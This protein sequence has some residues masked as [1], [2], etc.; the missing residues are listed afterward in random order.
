MSFNINEQNW[1]NH[2]P[3][4]E[5]TIGER[6]GIEANDG[7][8]MSLRDNMFAVA[9]GTARG[10]IILASIEE[11]KGK[12]HS[13]LK[14]RELR[15]VQGLAFLDSSC[16]VSFHVR[17]V[18]LWQMEFDASPTPSEVHPTHV[19]E[20]ETKG[21]PQCCAYDRENQ[22]IIVG[23][24]RGNLSYFLIINQ[25]D[26][27]ADGEN[28]IKS[29]CALTRVHQKQ[30]VTSIKWLNEN[31]IL[32]A[33]N[34]GCLHVSY[35]HGNLLQRGWSFSASCLTGI[36]SIITTNSS[37][38]AESYS[39]P[40][41][42]TGYHGNT[43]RV[44]DVESGYEYIRCDTGGRQRILDCRFN[45]N[46][47][48]VVAT[49]L[50][51]QLV[52]CQAKKDGSNRIFIQHLSM[53]NVPKTIRGH[54]HVARGVKLHGETIFDSSFFTL[55]NQELVFLVTASEDCTTRISAWKDGRIIDSVQ[56]TP[57][58]S[59]CRCI[60]VSKID[61]RSVLLVVGGGKLVLQFF[62]IKAGTNGSSTN[63]ARNLEIAFL[64]NGLTSKRGATIDH[65]IN[66][67]SALPL[68]DG[69]DRFHLVL[70]GDSEGS[71]HAF[72]ISEDC[73]KSYRDLRGII[74]PTTS[75]RPILCIQMLAV[76]GRALI[77]M[78]TTSGDIELF[79]LPVSL[80]NL[81]DH[82][83]RFEGLWNYI[84]QYQGHQ[85]G[86]NAITAQVLPSQTVNNKI[87][88]TISIV[89]GGDDQALCISRVY[90]EKKEG[91]NDSLR[92]AREPLS[93]VIPEASFS[94]IKGVSHVD[95]RHQKY[96]LSVGYSQQLSIWKFNPDEDMILECTSRLP[97][98]LGDVN[99]LSV[100]ISSDESTCLVAVCGMGVEVFRD[101]IS[102]QI[103]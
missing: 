91:V 50:T 47:T 100:Y 103:E 38:G 70:A 51:Y 40:I 19:L 97:V 81:R 52:V 57:Q 1:N 95:F 58:E 59:C 65:R 9:I 53:P 5:P 14:A 49:P 41:I 94:A 8:C 2:D 64:G 78:G 74:V 11:R 25:D 68:C 88:T 76:Y 69:N 96:L 75:E 45:T 44:M 98:D 82:W 30:H 18:A 7:N 77:L 48:T 61:D 72:L 29:V 26:T 86:T 17:A 20:L 89:S 15:A 42:V 102:K 73:T 84:G 101:K 90:L 21:I 3:W 85:M 63:S 71:S 37:T 16:L 24:S 66:A 60:S 27:N 56:L 93:K 4:W 23:D 87:K 92:L 33:G 28:R 32:S 79:D 31:T 43:Y 6:F 36:T 55:T 67:I 46:R 22:R 99:C 13:V 12:N 39:G 83:D 10:D 35:L 62:L 34:D 80:T 54:D